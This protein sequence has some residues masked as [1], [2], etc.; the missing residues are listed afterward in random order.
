[1]KFAAKEPVVGDLLDVE[2][3]A[4]QLVGLFCSKM[5]KERRQTRACRS[6]MIKQRVV[7]VEQD[8]TNFHPHPV[9]TLRPNKAH[10]RRIAIAGQC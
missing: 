4:G 5:P 6:L 7:Q 3:S 2:P 8:R 10:Y 1:M 9:P